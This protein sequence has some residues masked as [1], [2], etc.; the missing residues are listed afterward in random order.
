LEMFACFLSRR[1]THPI[2]LVKSIL[3]SPM[4]ISSHESLKLA[5]GE[6]EFTC[7]ETNHLGHFGNS[8]MKCIRPVV[9]NVLRCLIRAKSK[10]FILHGAHVPARWMTVLEHFWVR[11]L[12]ER[13]DPDE[14]VYD[15]EE[16]AHAQEDEKETKTNTEAELLRFKKILNWDEES[17]DGEWIDREQVSILSYAACMDNIIAV[18]AVLKSAK[19]KLSAKC[20]SEFID[21]RLH[22]KGFLYVGIPGLCTAVIAA[23]VLGSPDVVEVLLENGA[24]PYITDK[25]LNNPLMCACVYGRLENVKFWLNRYRQWDLQYVF[26]VLDE[27]CS[28]LSF[29]LYSHST[30]NHVCSWL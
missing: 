7:C 18:R 10:F 28:S 26:F 29:H 16:K 30:L 17:Y 4:W 11:G 27:D 22:R 19:T 9:E 2:L 3:E 8:S 5:V 13:H 23:M 20:F 21:V 1:K 14:E 25:N 15:R 24:N 12:S 6:A